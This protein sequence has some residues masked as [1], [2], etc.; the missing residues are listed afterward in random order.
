[1]KRVSA[2]CAA[3]SKVMYKK[4][5]RKKAFLHPQLH[6]SHQGL[7]AFLAK[8]GFQST[9]VVSATVVSAIVTSV[10]VVSETVVGAVVVESRVA[11][12]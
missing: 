4:V 5:N 12:S 10:V 3:L 9:V 2:I 7:V 8:S 1:M 11:V 6:L